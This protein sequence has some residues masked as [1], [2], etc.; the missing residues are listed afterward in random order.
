MANRWTGAHDAVLEL[1]PHGANRLLAALH[2]KGDATGETNDGPHLLHSTAINLPLPGPPLPGAPNLKGHLRVQIS[3][4]SVD[5]PPA[6]G[7][8]RVRVSIETYGWF[9]ALPDSDPAPEFLHGTL[10]LT[11]GVRVFK[12]H[13]QTLA[14]IGFASSDLEVE[15]TPAPGSG[16][17]AAD[18]ALVKATVPALLRSGRL[19]SQFAVG[20]LSAGSFAVRDLGFKTLRSASQSAFAVLLSLQA[21]G[22]P[23]P[24]PDLVSEIFLGIGDDAVVALGREFL[25]RVIFD[26]AQEPLGDIKAAGSKFIGAGPFGFTLSFNASVNPAS[27]SLQLQQDRIRISLNGSGSLSPGGSFG[28]RVTQHFSLGVTNGKLQLL[29][30]GGADF[31]VTQ[32]NPF[33]DLVFF[34]ITGLI[35]D[36]LDSA[37][38][39]VMAAANTELNRVLT[40]TTD[41]LL[42]H[43]SLPD[44]AKLVFTRASVDTDAVQVGSRIDIGASPPMVVRFKERIRDGQKELEAFESFIPGGTITRYIWKRIS[45]GGGVAAQV[46]EPHRFVTRVPLGSPLHADI[47]WPPVSWCVDVHGTSVTNAGVHPVVGSSCGVTVLT[48]S[49]NLAREERLTVSVPDGSGGVLADIDPWGGYRA[50]AFAGETERRGLL[51]VHYPEKAGAESVKALRALLASLGRKGPAVLATLIVDGRDVPAF[52]REA[53]ELA[54]THDPEGAWRRRF[55]LEPGGTVLAG[56]A[57]KDLWRSRGPLNQEELKRVLG[58]L[59]AG[60][61]GDKPR[62]PRQRVMGLKL[63]LGVLAPDVLFPCEGGVVLG[64]R[65]LGGHDKTLVFWTSWSEPALEELRR[66][67]AS[68]PRTCADGSPERH[69]V[70]CINDGEPRDRAERTLKERGLD[71]VLVTDEKRELAR[72]Y[73]VS[74]WPTVVRIDKRGRIAGVRLGLERAAAPERAGKA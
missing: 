7:P 63:G 73:G 57:G 56:P 65:K 33:L 19:Q 9:Q 49:L 58:A 62:L 15:F 22:G 5:V 45:L 14:E 13:G 23:I 12:C 52:A 40:E 71:V 37:L 55:K 20:A 26:F 41:G 60:E 66:V 47:G 64:L 36:E 54:V 53:P 69:I 72:R 46:D 6:A 29:T 28:F 2:R 59:V 3:T 1:A 27:L 74:C 24:N 68:G 48:V 18:V 21:P 39:N 31:D 11:V 25:T 38:G 30:V 61:W 44:D 10:V 42:E 70:L 50:H 67:S 34:L 32:A 51:L 43:L 4:P 17:T 8:G 35:E 16:A